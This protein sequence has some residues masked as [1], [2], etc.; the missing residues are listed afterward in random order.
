MTADSTTGPQQPVSAEHWLQNLLQQAPATSEIVLPTVPTT[1]ALHHVLAESVPTPTGLPLWDNSAMDGYALR[2]ADVAAAESESGRPVPLRVLGE[3]A[4]GSADDPAV[5]E[6]SAVRIMTGA[7]VPSDADAVVPVELTRDDDADDNDDAAWAQH[8]VEVLQPV[9]V[10]ANIRRAEEDIAAGALLAQRGQRLTPALLSALAAA[11]V[12]EV[13]VR[14]QPRVAVVVTGSELCA[15]GQPPLRGQI[16]ES[17]SVLIAG[18]LREL[19]LEPV[20]VRHSRD[21]AAGLDRLLTELAEHSDVIITTGG[22]GP[23]RHDVVRLALQNQPGVRRARVA[24]RPGAP[25]C[26]G[27]LQAGAFVFALPGNPVSAAVSFELFVRPTLLHMV[28]ATRL[29]R[30]RI[31]SVAEVGWRGKLGRLQVLP[32]RV[33]DGDGGDGVDGGVDGDKLR[34]APAVNARGSSHAVGGHGSIDGYALVGPARADVAAGE[35]V[36]VI[37][38]TP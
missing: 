4:A 15:P 34:C 21:D 25:Q 18:M 16:P 29:H 26:A 1:E 24:I 30:R 2:A 37:L 22:I 9:A 38:V 28:G 12:A 31:R 32:V 3:V 19:G 33:E 5:P 6:G 7:V 14:A 17:N 8:T 20:A 23:G 27:T 10:G 35:T 11:G 13:T 36:P